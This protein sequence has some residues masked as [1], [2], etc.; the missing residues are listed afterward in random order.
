MSK[1]LI[2]ALALMTAAAGMLA[3]Q[4]RGGRGAA[5]AGTQKVTAVRAGRLIDPESGTAA[6]N[7]VILVEG[8]RIKDVG[9]NVAIPPGA[10]VVDLSRLTLLP[11]LV[12]THTHEAMTYKE[13]P[14]NNV[15]YY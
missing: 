7:Q 10:D 2:V 9:P 12:D 1:R 13:M 6:A 15:Y 11:G 4:G 5:P 3:A 14:E 8:E